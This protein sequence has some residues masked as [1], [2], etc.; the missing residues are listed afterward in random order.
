MFGSD[1]DYDAELVARRR[2]AG[3]RAIRYPA[4]SPRDR[5]RDQ[6]LLDAIARAPQ[7]G[8]AHGRSSIDGTDRIVVYRK[9]ANY[10]VYV[11]VGRRWG[12]V[13]REWRIE[14]ATHLIFGIPATPGP[15]RTQPAGHT[16]GEAA[17]PHTLAQLQ[18]EVHRREFGA[19][20]RCASRRRWR[21]W[22]S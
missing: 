3:W 13:V 10:P 15:A 22:V 16:P 20:R 7:A 14:M 5:I 2:H 18:D 9:L 4:H 6:L 8:M 17:E 11:T 1:T 21:R 12:S 19:R